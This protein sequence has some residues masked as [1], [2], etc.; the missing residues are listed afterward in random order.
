MCKNEICKCKKYTF[1][2]KIRL[3]REKYKFYAKISSVSVKKYKCCA[4]NKIS[5]CKKY[6]VY[7]KLR[8]VNV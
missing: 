8:S 6:K 1:C 7:A 3:L 4:K 2:A 5:K